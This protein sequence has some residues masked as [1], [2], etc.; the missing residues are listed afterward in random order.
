MLEDNIPVI[1]H[2]YKIP[3]MAEKK[4]QSQIETMLKSGVI[5]KSTSPYR[6]PLVPILKKNGDWRLCVDYRDLNAKTVKDSYVMPIIDDIIENFHGSQIFS[7]LDAKSGCYQIK[8]AEE[9][10]VK[11][12]FGCLFGN[13]EF[14]RMPF[15]L[16][17]APATYQRAMN[18]IFQDELRSFVF[19]YIDD[20]IVFSPDI[21]SHQKHLHIVLNKLQTH[22]VKLNREKCLFYQEQLKILGH[23]VNKNGIT[24]DT[25]RVTALNSLEFPSDVKRLQSFL[26][27]VSYCR[28]FI[29]NLAALSESFYS[30]IKK[31]NKSRQSK[32]A[33]TPDLVLAFQKIK[34]EISKTVCVFAVCVFPDPNLR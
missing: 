24:I 14:L 18:T 16:V 27:L 28:K 11:T 32:I 2:L 13:F 17:N 19:V 1:K 21:E 9:D 12:A 34:A 33:E 10:I 6:A 26:G 15:G 8:I 22:G 5:R 29:R 20:I 30:Q 3:Q 25:E 4:I 7:I 23:I 31:A